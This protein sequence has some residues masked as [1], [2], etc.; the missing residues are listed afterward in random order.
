MK[1]KTVTSADVLEPGLLGSPEESQQQGVRRAGMCGY[2][3]EACARGEV[4]LRDPPCKEMR[5]QEPA[6]SVSLEGTCWT[7]A[8]P[9]QGCAQ[10]TG[11]IRDRRGTRACRCSVKKEWRKGKRQHMWYAADQ[12]DESVKVEE[13]NMAQGH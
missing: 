12:S 3:P 10:F 5:S 1:Q 9:S 13:R 8:N 6:S 2:G 11:W 7:R 4:G